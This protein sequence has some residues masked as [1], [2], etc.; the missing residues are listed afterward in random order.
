MYS[1]DIISYFF[2][3]FLLVLLRF[4]LLLSVALLSDFALPFPH[5]LVHIVLFLPI[6]NL[7]LVI[8]I[9][10]V[11]LVVPLFFV[12]IDLRRRRDNAGFRER[13]FL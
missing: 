4:L 1:L 8:I 9:L 5:F 12:P 2:L 7:V 13:D 10:L 6:S 3:F 11:L